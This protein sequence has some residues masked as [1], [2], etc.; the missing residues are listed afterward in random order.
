MIPNSVRNE[1][2]THALAVLLYTNPGGQFCGT[3]MTE[4]VG[5]YPKTSNVN[6]LFYLYFLRI[7]KNLI[8][9]IRCYRQFEFVAK[10][11]TDM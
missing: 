7:L 11:V 3:S 1:L 2:H 4:D 8:V 9:Y 5:I 10:L 6:A